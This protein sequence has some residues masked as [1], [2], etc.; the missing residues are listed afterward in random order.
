MQNDHWKGDRRLYCG[1]TGTGKTT[2]GAK[3]FLAEEARW[4]FVYD[5]E[6]LFSHRYGGKP[7][8][9][10]ELR[11]ATEAGGLVCYDPSIDGIVDYTVGTKK[12]PGALSFF[13]SFILDIGKSG[14]LPGRKVVWIDEL[15]MLSDTRSYSPDL[16]GLWQ[17]GRKY[18]VDIFAVS[19]CPASI[20]KRLSFNFI[21]TFRQSPPNCE[22]LAPYGISQEEQMALGTHGWIR[23]DTRTGHITR[24]KI[25]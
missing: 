22:A 7:V 20:S 23:V 13:C 15:D 11:E 8:G 12:E 1:V 9:Q 25:K 5:P 3:E 4:H 6:E 16:T 21:T 2:M 18:E 19:S 10:A 24:S 14:D 17:T